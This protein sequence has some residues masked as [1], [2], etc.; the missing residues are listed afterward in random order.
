MRIVTA[1]RNV[2]TCTLLEQLWLLYILWSKFHVPG[3]SLLGPW[4][5]TRKL[6][7]YVY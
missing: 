7:F 3:Y 5:K 4:W 1:F 6:H 2:N